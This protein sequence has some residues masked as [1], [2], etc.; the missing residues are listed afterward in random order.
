VDSIARLC[1]ELDQLRLHDALI[2]P[3]E[4]YAMA[5]GPVSA[6]NEAE[7]PLRR[8]M[9]SIERDVAAV[10]ASSTYAMGASAS[11]AA[12]TASTPTP[13]A[14]ARPPAAA[15]APSTPPV[16][17]EPAPAAAAP[18]SDP[19]REVPPALRAPAPS[20]AA[21]AD[22]R[23]PLDGVPPALRVASSMSATP[24]PARSTAAGGTPGSY[25]QVS[26]YGDLYFISGQIAVNHDTGRF[27][28][29]AKIDEQTRATLE[30]VRRVLEGERL[31]LANVVATT[32]YL[33]DI[34]DLA[35]MD[36]AYEA[37]FRTRLP[38]RSVVEAKNL[39]RGARV[40]ISVVAGR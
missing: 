2:A 10:L 20:L 12:S 37:E 8:P 34:N 17:R 23:P 22:G 31:T 5:K 33:R 35:A 38:A 24:A 3:S 6:S 32:V 18:A 25:T 9:T 15:P 7:D 27:D 39:P 11:A 4:A 36:R 16:P 40:Q 21:A 13:A 14:P 30:N 29:D 28:P 19:A 26:R 1:Y